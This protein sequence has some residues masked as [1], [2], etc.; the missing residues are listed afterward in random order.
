MIH[1]RAW[2]FLLLNFVWVASFSQ[3]LQSYPSSSQG[4]RGFAPQPG[5]VDVP[6]FTSTDISEFTQ[7]D[8]VRGS[9]YLND[10]FIVGTVYYNGFNE[11]SLLPLRYN[12]LTDEFEVVK[13]DS[14]YIFAE[15]G[16]IDRIILEDEI[17]T[18]VE[19]SQEH[20]LHG[21]VKMWDFEVPT[22][23]TKIQRSVAVKD[24][25]SHPHILYDYTNPVTIHPMRDE[26]FMMKS[27]TEF[28]RIRGLKR[29]ADIT[30]LA[31][32]ISSQSVR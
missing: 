32:E 12:I 9:P 29:K 20:D 16:Q 2:L 25:P 11:V 21:F 13:N 10:H 26:H 1:A 19:E 28:V 6:R 7:I 30:R 15:P 18:Y 5:F 17:F 22:I 3:P 14:I 27:G 31:A 8:V 4:G 24:N 23:F